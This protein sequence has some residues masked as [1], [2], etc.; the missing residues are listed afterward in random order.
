MS[1]SGI[2]SVF[3]EERTCVDCLIPPDVQTA[4]INVEVPKN[5]LSKLR[6]SEL[7]QEVTRYV[8]RYF[9]A[10]IEEFYS[11]SKPFLDLL[12]SKP[13]QEITKQQKRKRTMLRNIFQI[14]N[15]E[16]PDFEKVSQKVYPLSS[17]QA[18]DEEEEADYPYG[19]KVAFLSKYQPYV[20]KYDPF[21]IEHIKFIDLYYVLLLVQDFLKQEK[22]TA[23]RALHYHLKGTRTCVPVGRNKWKPYGDIP[24]NTQM[25]NEW[26]KQL[27]FTGLLDFESIIDRRIQEHVVFPNLT[28]VAIANTFKPEI[29]ATVQL[30]NTVQIDVD[31]P[32]LI[33]YCEKST[34]EPLFERIAAEN[35]IGYYVAGGQI[36]L[37]GVYEIYNAIKKNPTF[38]EKTGKGIIL[39]M[40]DYDAGGLSIKISIA[41]KL[42]ALLLQE[43]E[44]TRPNIIVANLFYRDDDLNLLKEYGINPDVEAM[45][46][47]GESVQLRKYLIDQLYELAA[48]MSIRKKRTITVETLIL[49][50]IREMFGAQYI[51]AKTEI[52]EFTA[53]EYR[54][55]L[56]QVTTTFHDYLAK[57][58]EML[59]QLEQ[60][61][62]NASTLNFDAYIKAIDTNVKKLIG[63]PIDV[64]ESV[65]SLTK[66]VPQDIVLNLPPVLPT[67]EEE[68]LLKT[69]SWN[70]QKREQVFTSYGEGTDKLRKL[71]EIYKKQ[72]A[73]ERESKKA[74]KSKQKKT[75]E[76]LKTEME[77]ES[78]AEVIPEVVQIEPIESPPIP[79]VPKKKKRGTKKT[80]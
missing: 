49:D 62:P 25:L 15:N 53:S 71:K 43:P 63:L 47:S 24:Y 26:I 46:E 16:T 64:A 1:Q 72:E 35:Y 61:I 10:F 8:R 37:T 75:M 74:L 54:K 41:R 30:K 19:T 44:A 34:F 66:Y 80:T 55:N 39:L 45:K 5:L 27:R 58:T 57:N 11:Q 65:L 52:D 29:I 68:V 33:L 73:N 51:K 14:Q 70:P 18:T 59:E 48:V 50:R 31:I 78:K 32:R 40:G 4:L 60:L 38:P 20:E 67:I 79:E 23:V 28:R 69:Y 3:G 6:Q 56:N 7:Q 22:R 9:Q 76:L 12:K 13:E 21:A 42:Q 2:L 77:A 17:S 36:S